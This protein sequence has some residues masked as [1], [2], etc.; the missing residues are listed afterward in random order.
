ME[1]FKCFQSGK[2]LQEEPIMLIITLEQQRGIDL[3]FQGITV[4]QH[5]CSHFNE[6]IFSH[7]ILP[8]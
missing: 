6:Y 4:H 5:F 1:Y 2:T 7:D 8:F 3:M